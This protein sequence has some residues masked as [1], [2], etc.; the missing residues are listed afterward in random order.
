MPAIE[1]QPVDNGVLPA[2]GSMFQ[3]LL[4]R[5]AHASDGQITRPPGRPRTRTEAH[6]AA[7]LREHG[8]LAG[9]F[10]ERFG[11]RPRSD[12]E[13]LTAHITEG[14][15]QRGMRAS[16]ATSAEMKRKLKTLRN[17]L[18]TARRLLQPR[19]ENPLLPGRTNGD[20]NDM[21][22][23]ALTSKEIFYAC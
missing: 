11:R 2:S 19:P 3:K 5:D 23:R 1:R 13:L 10:V 21:Q 22:A 16:R 18:S 9:W 15:K 8:Y 12:A 17:E 6:Y 7:L 4:S 20:I 14:L